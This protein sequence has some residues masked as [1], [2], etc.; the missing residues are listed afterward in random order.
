M[1]SNFKPYWVKANSQ[2]P[3]APDALV[4]YIV[5]KLGLNGTGQHYPLAVVKREGGLVDLDAVQGR[6]VLSAILGAVTVFSDPS[7]HIGIQSELSLAAQFYQ[8]PRNGLHRTELS[9]TPTWMRQ[10]ISPQWECGVREFP[11]ISTCLVLGVAFD[12][13]RGVGLSVL[14][15]PLGTMFSNTNMEYAMAVVDITD[16]NAILYG[17]IAFRSTVMI[18]VSE[19]PRE[20]DEYN[21]W[22]DSD[23][24]GPRE[25]RLEEN[26]TREPLSAAEYLTKFEYEACDDLV[27]KLDEV[28]L[29]DPTV[30]DLIWPLT[31]AALPAL[32]LFPAEKDAELTA[33]IDALLESQ[34]LDI[35][36]ETLLTQLTGTAHT[37]F[38]LRQHLQK[39]SQDI[40]HLPKTGQLLGLAFT[41][42]LHLD[43]ASFNKLSSLSVIAALETTPAPPVSLSLNVDT[44]HDSSTTI[45]DALL[46]RP[47]LKSLYLLQSPTRTSDTPNRT[48]FSALATHPG[49]PLAHFKKLHIS[50]LYSSPFIGEPFLPVGSRPW[51]HLPYPLQYLLLRQRTQHHPRQ[52]PI[53]QV[54]FLN[55]LLL[56][57][58]KFAAGLLMYLRSLLTSTDIQHHSRTSLWGFA[59]CPPTLTV[60]QKTRVEVDPLPFY[61]PDPP[62]VRELPEESWNV[63][64]ERGIHVDVGN[65]GPEGEGMSWM[66]DLKA[67]WV[68]YALVRVVKPGGVKL[69]QDG[70]IKERDVE[71]VDLEGFLYRVDLGFSKADGDTVWRRMTEFEREMEE[72]PGQGGLGKGMPKVGV[73]GEK[74]ARGLL[75]DFLTDARS[76]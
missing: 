8:D 18:H 10:S 16:L 34:N 25:L 67:A 7:N 12:R 37:K 53:S 54:H 71:I 35:I 38:I 70:G 13:E 2:T 55:P 42:E 29:I 9:N 56:T 47:T 15:A 26:R 64:V 28:E 36:S 41:N 45:I 52:P 3:A 40:G 63:I 73:I 46:T 5:A 76:T 22:G 21:D 31:T 33:L 60:D 59:C 51:L 11:F 65:K 48:F 17:I 75:A 30:L 69:D 66:P 43:L 62:K 6:D 24:S 1:S 61:T 39:R 23:P 72:W 68:R 19:R 49:K 44:L 50:G 4:V 32:S 57:P 14:P 58:E 20:V 27:K 74:E